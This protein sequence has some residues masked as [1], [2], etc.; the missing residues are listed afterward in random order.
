MQTLHKM[1][2]KYDIFISYSRKDLDKVRP[3]VNELESLGVK[4]WF[5]LNG[6]ESG[7]QFVNKIAKAIDNSDS[8]IYMYSENS[9]EGEWTQKEVMYAKRQNKVVRPLLINGSMPDQGWFSLLYGNIDCINITN[10]HQRKKL[11][12]NIQTLYG[13]HQIEEIKEASTEPTEVT[14]KEAE[15]FV[16]TDM[17]CH[18]QR[19]HRNLIVARVG[20]ENVIYLP[21]GRHKL[22]FVAVED[23]SINKDMLYE[24]KDVTMSDFIEVELL[25]IVKNRQEKERLEKE[26]KERKA[27]EEEERKAKAEAKRIADEKARKKAEEEAKQKAKEEEERQARLKEMEGVFLETFEKDGKWG[28]KAGFK[29]CIPCI[30]EKVHDFSEGIA[31]VCL[32]GKFGCINKLG[33]TV[34]PFNYDCIRYFSEGSAPAS[35]NGRWG[36]IDNSNKVIIPFEYE[37]AY[38]FHNGLASVRRNGK[39]GLI[40]KTGKLI[41]PFKYDDAITEYNF[42]DGYVIAK[43]NGK[44]GVLDEKWNVVIPF[45]YE[46]AF[47]KAQ[48]LIQVKFHGKWGFIDK[49]N[50]VVVPFEYEEVEHFY[51]GLAAVKSGSWPNERWGFIDTKGNVIVPPKYN[52]VKFFSEDRAAVCKYVGGDRLNPRWG[53]IDPKGNEV[54]PL[55]YTYTL[56]VFFCGTARVLDETGRE[57]AIDKNGKEVKKVR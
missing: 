4:V 23:E 27:R 43:H 1:E 35:L 8:M 14:V 40:N 10:E 47:W 53:F 48:E 6:V 12:T 29:E 13:T 34:I 20:E 25:E 54:I 45:M 39:W 19:F 15:I 51:E 7:E 38:P 33:D 16:E 26:E 28:Y 56:R 22:Q 32:N 50:K 49:S 11:M 17:D 5:D 44:C 21:K 41:V 46:D 24:V 42:K 36:F 3:I 9:V 31:A 52:E 30:Y 57:I 18:V 37:D 2:K 55:V